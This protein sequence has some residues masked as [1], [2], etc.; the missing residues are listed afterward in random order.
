M[1]AVADCTVVFPLRHDPASTHPDVSGL[2]GKAFERVNWRDAFD[3]Y[4]AEERSALW[5]AKTAFDNT[6]TS[7]YIAARDALFPQAV[8][9]VH[10]A[11]AFRNRAGHKLHETMEAVGLWEYLKGGATRAKGTFTFVDVCGGP[12]AFSQAL[13]AM[14]KE[15][16]LRLRGFGLTLRNVKGLDWYTDLPSRSFF[17]CYGID[18]TGNVFK[19]ENIESLCSLTC[20]ENVRLVVADGGFDVPTEVVNFQETISCRIVYGQWLSAVKLL[21][22]GGCFVLKLFDCFSPFTRAILFLTT[23]LYESVQVVKP[24]HSRVVNSERYLVC[25]GFIG[26]PKQWLEHFERC[27][28]EGFVDNDNIPTV[29]PTSLFSGDKIFGADVERMS[30]TIASNQVSGLHAILEKLQSKPAMEEAKS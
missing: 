1:P 2:V 23:H 28:Q 8:S 15:H 24:R 13:F 18:G 10:G 21:R 22:P 19:L 7:A 17:P 20:K 11:V 30:A 27:Y 6:D 14:G 4:L 3:T 26:A 29:L 25:I 16:K 12:G 9:G 5:A